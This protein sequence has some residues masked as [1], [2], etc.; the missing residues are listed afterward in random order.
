MIGLDKVNHCNCIVH[1]LILGFDEE[2]HIQ[3]DV[4][5]VTGDPEPLPY[6]WCGRERGKSVQNC[7][8]FV[9]ESGGA[10]GKM[11]LV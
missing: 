8:N 5:S 2:T 10:G 11:T 9:R 4:F 7:I 6:I 3:V 1:L